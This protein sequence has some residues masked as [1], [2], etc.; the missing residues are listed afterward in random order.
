[1][2]ISRRWAYEYLE[3]RAHAQFWIVADV[4]AFSITLSIITWHGPVRAG[5][6]AP[7]TAR[8]HTE[9]SASRT[10]LVLYTMPFV[11]GGHFALNL[12]TLVL[13]WRDSRTTCQ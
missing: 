5:D 8:H 12:A 6:R 10:N 13:R 2:F 1:M 4:I 9:G 7:I 3:A 11:W